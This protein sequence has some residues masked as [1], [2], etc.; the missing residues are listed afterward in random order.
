LPGEPG[1]EWRI[2]DFVVRPL[3]PDITASDA[4]RPHGL[5]EMS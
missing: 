1:F 3:S 2:D 5:R 4:R